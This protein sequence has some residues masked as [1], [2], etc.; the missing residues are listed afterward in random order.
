[1]RAGTTTAI[2]VMRN[3]VATVGDGSRREC[4]VG[5]QGQTLPPDRAPHPVSSVADLVAPHPGVIAGGHGVFGTI[6]AVRARQ[7]LS[8]QG[9]W[10]V[11]L[12]GEPGGR[13]V[14]RRVEGNWQLLQVDDLTDAQLEAYESGMQHSSSSAEATPPAAPRGAR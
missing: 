7:P 6:A 11:S 5:A 12:A 10:R 2:L 1:M 3:R 9:I 13:L 4:D 14:R 8:D